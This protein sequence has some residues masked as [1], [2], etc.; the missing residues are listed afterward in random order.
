MVI[1]TAIVTTIGREIDAA[2]LDADARTRLRRCLPVVRDAVTAWQ[3]GGSFAAPGIMVLAVTPLAGVVI[4]CDCWVEDVDDVHRSV[5]LHALHQSIE[6]QQPPMLIA[7][8]TAALGPD[9]RAAAER[10]AADMTE[11]GKQPLLA[12][13]VSPQQGN[14]AAV[15]LAITVALRR[16]PRRAERC[17]SN[18]P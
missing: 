9:G 1:G 10:D 4:H 5:A 2:E 13:L 7:A 14:D 11:L 15:V 12:V 16:R 3:D 6:A 18:C 17:T 8:L